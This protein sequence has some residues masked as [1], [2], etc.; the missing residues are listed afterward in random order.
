MIRV[1]RPKPGYLRVATGSHVRELQI[2]PG[3]RDRGGGHVVV[4]SRSRHFR[5]SPRLLVV[6][7]TA[8]TAQVQQRLPEAD[9]DDAVQHH[10]AGHV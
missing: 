7:A 2:G 5:P 1:R 3:G 4:V 8:V 6:M 10:V 9:V